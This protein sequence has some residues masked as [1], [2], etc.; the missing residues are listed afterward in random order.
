M[1]DIPLPGAIVQSL[2]ERMIDAQ[3]SKPAR[4]LYD[5]LVLEHTPNFIYGHADVG[6]SWWSRS[7]M[8]HLAT[9]MR[10]P[11]VYTDLQDGEHRTVTFADPEQAQTN[12]KQWAGKHFDLPREQQLLAHKNILEIRSPERQINNLESFLEVLKRQADAGT[13]NDILIIDSWHLI[14]ACQVDIGKK[15]EMEAVLHNMFEEMKAFKTILALGHNTKGDHRNRKNDIPTP[16]GSGM[17]GIMWQGNIAYMARPPRD[18][19]ARIFVQMKIK[20]EWNKTT[21]REHEP[22]FALNTQTTTW[23]P[24]EKSD[25]KLKYHEWMQEHEKDDDEKAQLLTMY[26]NGA[27]KADAVSFLSVAR[28]V[29]LDSARRR[30]ERMQESEG[31]VDFNVP[32]DKRLDANQTT[33]L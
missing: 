9:D 6:K 16:M 17:L 30:L 2:H 29:K 3:K 28:G 18:P 33:L 21:Y 26:R 10:V 12:L 14:W 24:F 27:T 32:P 15:T 31:F 7:L 23:Q 11:G 5:S 1:A 13:H 8:M 22:C 25:V 19:Q 20:D 4:Q